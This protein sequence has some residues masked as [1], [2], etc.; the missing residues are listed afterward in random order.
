[1]ADDSKTVRLPLKQYRKLVY[2][3]VATDRTLGELLADA[4][5]AYFTEHQGIAEEVRAEVTRLEGTPLDTTRT[6]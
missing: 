2:L 1:M 5:D 3:G 4:V 6:G